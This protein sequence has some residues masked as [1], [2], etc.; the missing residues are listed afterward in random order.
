[1]LPTLL[2]VRPFIQFY[3]FSILTFSELS[4]IE[5]VLKA[6]QEQGYTTPTPIQQQAIPVVL[7][8]KDLIACAQTGTGKTAAFAIPTL[9]MLHSKG[10]KNGNGFKHIRTLVLTPTRELALQIDDS[11]A[12]YGKHTGLNHQVIFGGVPQHSQTIAL[13]NGTDI[14]IAT[15]G[16]LLDLMNQGYVYLDHLEMLILDE[17]DRMLDMGFIHDV[18]RITRVLPK[19]RQTLLFSATMPLQIA[20]LAASLMKSPVKV[21]VTPVSS[22]AEKINQH[23]FMVDKRDKQTLL[24]HL[25]TEQDIKRTLVFT[26]TKHGADRIAKNLNNANIKADAIHG[27]KTQGARQRA[28]ENFK[29]GRL[30]VLVATDIAARGIDVDNLSHVINYDIPDIPETYVHRIGRTGR[31]GEDGIAYSFCDREERGALK[32]IHKLIAKVIPVVEEHPFK[33]KHSIQ[34]HQ[35]TTN[36]PQQNKRR[37]NNKPGNHQGQNKKQYTA[38]KADSITNN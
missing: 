23:V 11:F 34:H 15:P 38:R 29:N 5:P 30:K 7:E 6:V 20:Q 25:L 28:L 24:V 9:Q 10:H 19:E 17:A 31:A 27:N 33:I 12:A 21:E 2:A 36:V 37:N 35:H 3:N 26:R 1:M 16:R 13:R 32:D 4:L 18:K 8:G 14:L 22:T